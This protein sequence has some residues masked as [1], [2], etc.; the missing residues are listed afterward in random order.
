MKIE[1]KLKWINRKGFEDLESNFME[2]SPSKISQQF[3]EPKV[4]FR[5]QKST[6]SHYFRQTCFFI[7]N[8][9]NRLKSAITK[10]YWIKRLFH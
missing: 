6:I 8:N 10:L 5:V 2:L 7:V 3:S 4:H 9:E 1:L